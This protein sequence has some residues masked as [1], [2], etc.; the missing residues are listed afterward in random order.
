MTVAD[1]IKFL[2]KKPQH[3][4]VAYKRYSEQC[5]LEAQDIDIEDLCEPRP[6]GWIENA[7]PDKPK[8]SYLILPGN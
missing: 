7:R 3:L 4:Q 1:L 6:D 2:Q 5:L 8:Q